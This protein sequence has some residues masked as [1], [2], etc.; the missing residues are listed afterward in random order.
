M[1]LRSQLLLISLVILAL[2]LAGWQFARQVEKTLRAGH[3]EAFLSTATST[4]R[5][6]AERDDIAWP[7]IQGQALHVHQPAVPP[8]LDGYAD[9]WRGFL[10]DEAHRPDTA[11]QVFA[12]ERGARLY[13]LFE[14]TSDR[15]IY[16]TPAQNNG[17]R[18][19]LDFV[20]EDGLTGRV[21]IT[22]LAPGWIESRG[23]NTVGWPRVQGYWQPGTQG[24]TVELQ[25]PESFM[26][27]TMGWE[28]VDARSSAPYAEAR[29]FSSDG[30]MHLLRPEAELDRALEAVLPDQTRAWIALPSSWVIAHA[31]RQGSED[32][33]SATPGW[34]DTLL[35]EGLAS[36]S[37][38]TG[39]TR[40]AATIRLEPE[41]EANYDS[42]GTW[43]TRVNQPGV[44]LTTRVPIERAGRRIGTL[45]MERE[46]DQLLLDSNRAVLRLL[47]ISLAVFVGVTLLLVAYATWLS[48]RVRRLRDGVEAAV[49]DDGKVRQTLKPAKRSDELGELQHSVSQLLIRLREHQTYLH[50]LADKLAHELRTPLAMIR[51]SLDNLEHVNDP[52]AIERYRQRA[53]EGSDRL[54]RIFQAMSQASRIEES[55]MHE[56][57]EP[58][59]MN[60]FLEHY[61]AACRD[62][63]QDRTFHLYQPDAPII[64]RAVPDLLAQLIDKLIDN[65]IDFSP[66]HSVIRLRLQQTSDQVELDIENDGPPLP[67]SSETLF[68][69]MV[70]VRDNKNADVHLGLGLS[71]VRLIT[72][73]HQGTIR[74]ENL[75][76]GVRFRLRIPVY[77]ST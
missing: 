23:R 72:E 6:L 29:T 19:M 66:N 31:E 47:G 15:Q 43:T 37:I 20:R 69:S 63:Y 68:D 42:S 51:S 67:K 65:A 41:T 49:S 55:L 7:E 17:D 14:V 18:L 22:P 35:F 5:Q 30:A 56:D 33:V 8:F 48:E 70:S 16:S 77:C 11:V 71:I 9:D 39:P 3:A 10:S 34:L 26:A 74:A 44:L 4:A 12:A 54:N 40:N 32:N 50:T 13:L 36:D 53:S 57:F 61:L 52:D 25:L 60:E 62:T 2:P 38:A 28:M 27:V 1:T 24:W 46:A 76:N 75:P 59:P 73:H 58:V 45:L 64:A 21:E